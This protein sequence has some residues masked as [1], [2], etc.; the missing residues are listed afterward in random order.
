MRIGVVW[1]NQGCAKHFPGEYYF[2]ENLN[3]FNESYDLLWLWGGED[4]GSSLYGESPRISK[5][6]PK[7][8]SERD[9]LELALIE[10]AVKLEIP[11]VGICRGAQIA[12]VYAGGKLWQHVDGHNEGRH[13][14]TTFTGEK[15]WANSFHHQMMRPTTDS[16][17]V[18]WSTDTLSPTKEDYLG[19]IKSLG[20]EPEVV[21][22]PSINCL[23]IQA[24]P[25]W[26][27]KDDPFVGKCRAWMKEFLNV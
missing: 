10:K 27:S 26:L 20:P 25:E 11:I 16:F 24:H 23:G 12:C 6:V 9:T 14:L 21:Y 15:V 1:E 8:P 13:E 3:Q 18:A 4:I 5:N 7:G 17:I 2:L 22:F 19:P